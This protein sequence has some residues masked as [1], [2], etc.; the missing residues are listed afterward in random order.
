MQNNLKPISYNMK[1]LLFSLSFL[2]ASVMATAAPRSLAQMKAAAE[3]ALKVQPAAT[4]RGGSAQLEVMKQGAQYTVLGYATGGFAV[5]ANDDR[6]DAVLG[7]SDTE[8]STGDIPP[9]MLW[10]MDAAD[11]AMAQK[12]ASGEAAV[13]GEAVR[14]SSYPEAVDYLMASEWDQMAPYNNLASEKVGATVYTGCVATAMAQIMYYHK[15]PTKGTSGKNY[16]VSS[17]DPLTNGKRLAVSFQATTYD[18]DNMLPKYS[19]VKYNDAQADA[20]ATLMYHCGV[21]VEMSYGTATVGGSGAYDYNVPLAAAQYFGYA[22]KLYTRDI[23]P[24]EQWMNI[25]Y[26]EISNGRPVFYGGVTSQWFGHAFVFD[27]YDA[28][29]RVHVNWGWSGSGNGYFDVALLDSSQGS[30]AYQQDM[31]VMHPGGQPEIP[32]TS[33]WGLIDWPLQDAKGSFTVTVRGMQLSYQATQL[34]NF[35]AEDFDGN[36]G[37]LAEPVDGGTATVLDEFNMTQQFG[38]VVEYLAGLTRTAN[39]VSIAGLEDG[40]YRIYMA[41][42]A[43]TET[44]WQPVHS[45]ENIVNNYILTISNGAASVEEGESDW[46]TGIENVTAEGNGGDGIVR[47]YTA[48]GVLVY[49]AAASGFSIDDVPATGLL[50]VKNGAKTVKVVK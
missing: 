8:F 45:N 20:V 7:Y 49:T 1:K 21:S 41:S 25:I 15:S 6:F 4:T 37:L 18:W 9:A 42:K 35:D 13:S 30:F 26:E 36:L 39:T 46:T 12:L 40:T 32:Y 27:G 38:G 33:Q 34:L 31:V 43:T 22:A 3:G 17:D 2:L 11:A 23:Y 50:I 28:A 14:N 47:V 29:G 48:D 5:I 24:T 16:A 10:W 44:A 19:T